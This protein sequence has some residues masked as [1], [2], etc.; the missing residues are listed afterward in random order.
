MLHHARCRKIGVALSL[1]AGVGAAPALG[2]I[3]GPYA[4]DANTLQLWHLDEAA[5][6]TSAANA[7][8][9]GLTMQGVLNG[10]TLGN[11]SFPGFGTSLDVSAGS[12]SLVSND[13]P[14]VT[15]P[16]HRAVLAGAP[17][18]STMNGGADLVD[19]A[20]DDVDLTYADPTTG[21]FTFEAIVKFDADYDPLQPF[22][23]VG[24]TPEFDNPG[25]YAMEILTGEG[26]VGTDGRP[27][28]FRV[29]QVGITAAG[30]AASPK[31]EFHNIAFQT[32][33]QLYGVI[34]TTGPHAINNTDWFHVAVAYNGVDFE[35]ENLKFYWS[36][37]DPSVTQANQLATVDA[38]GAPAVTWMTDLFQTPHDFAIGG[39]T[40]NNGTG[41]GEGENFY[42][43]ID[44]VR[45]SSVARGPD[46]FLFGPGA[47]EDADF[48]ADG[49]VDG[50]D[51]LRWQ[52]GLGATGAAATVANGNA[53]GD[54]VIDGADLAIWRTQF[55]TAVGAA[56][57][58]PEPATAAI[59]LLGLA[60][61]RRRRRS[62]EPFPASTTICV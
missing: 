47:A 45:I 24:P 14:R 20:I 58:V 30:D 6:A 41:F 19:D 26:D 55:A 17:V 57:A 53:N 40:R 10:A 21:A 31:L 38:T 42:G 56:A 39:E 25:S 15:M 49:D 50:A 35:A 60:A 12:D 43:Q 8:A 59:L 18:L 62:C 16:P 5:S 33:N 22:R 34:P 4:V 46:Q 2:A 54:N 29:V 11:A 36:R 52:R 27:F 61:L 44:E 7:V 48:D 32:G 1:A 28:Q 9:G 13:N 23:N 37:L 3:S 51:F